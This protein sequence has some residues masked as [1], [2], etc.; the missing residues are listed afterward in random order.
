MVTIVNFLTVKS[1]T[2]AIHIKILI[3]DKSSQFFKEQSSNLDHKTNSMRPIILKI[4]CPKIL[5]LNITREIRNIST[6][7]INNSSSKIAIFTITAIKI[8]NT[9]TGPILK[10]N[11]FQDDEFFKFSII[12]LIWKLYLLKKINVDYNN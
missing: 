6:M 1:F 9:N 2:Q 7:Q 12:K 8:N 4:K 11:F 3:T 10:I 5:S